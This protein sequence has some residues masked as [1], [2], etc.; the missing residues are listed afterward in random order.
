MQKRM[1]RKAILAELEQLRLELGRKRRRTQDGE[2]RPVAAA[3]SRHSDSAG[4]RPHP[5]AAHAHAG[6]QRPAPPQAQT[7]QSE[8]LGGSSAAQAGQQLP[9][10][11]DAVGEPAS[12]TGI[13]AAAPPPSNQTH[14]VNVPPPSNPSNQM[15][16]AASQPVSA[17]TTMTA[18][19]RS[20]RLSAKRAGER[21]TGAS[22]VQ[23]QR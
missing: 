4:A 10:G 23:Q 7:W 3:E 11:H 8:G 20:Q 22:I 12:G 16:P 19:R 15:P 17:A 6:Q 14:A 5:H 13:P 18:T 1:K 21:P 2:G 9:E